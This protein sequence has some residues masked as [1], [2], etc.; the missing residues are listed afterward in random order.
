MSCCGISFP[1]RYEDREDA[2]EQPF[3]RSN[4]EKTKHE[5]LS[6]AYAPSRDRSSKDYSLNLAQQQQPTD[7]SVSL[8]VTELKRLLLERGVDFRDCLEKRDLIARLESSRD[9]APR[10]SGGVSE[11]KLTPEETLIASIFNRASQSVAFIQTTAA[12]SHLRQTFPLN[13][14]DEVPAG[15]GSGFLWDS[16]GHVVTNCHV[17]TSGKR[18]SAEVVPKSVRVKC[19]GMK[20]AHDATVVGVDPN[21]DLAVLRL[22]ISA[23]DLP[24]PPPIDVGTSNDLQVGQ[25]ALAIG[26]PFGLD[27]TLTTGV[28]SALGRQVGGIKGCIQTDAAI[29]PGSSGGPLLDS[30]GHLIGVS[31]VIISPGDLG[32][33]VGIGFAIP[34][35]TVRRVVNQLIRYGRVVRPT[36][37][38][39][40]ADDRITLSI[41]AQLR[42]RLDGVLVVEV[43]PR[44]PAEQAGI[45]ASALLVDGTILLGDLI[46]SIDNQRVRQVEDLLSA[47]EER[48]AGET[49]KVRVLRECD[50]FRAETLM[51]TLAAHSE[52]TNGRHA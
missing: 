43:D 34:V 44:S 4:N 20:K 27:Y 2:A 46:V 9:K 15:A 6:I 1:Y 51:V 11:I 40:L 7:T 28:V 37:G 42:K 31:A 22:Q 23:A 5:M 41:Q 8:S 14:I 49:V 35:D 52:T 39:H 29:N 25:T 45:R 18:E 12:V 38:V 33:N 30:R 36:M 16:K 10:S 13:A 24:L 26:N 21:T 48:R 17:V 50:Q 47:V 3:H 32:G 19:Q